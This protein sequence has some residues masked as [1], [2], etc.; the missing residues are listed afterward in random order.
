M[1][2]KVEL[3]K[4]FKVDPVLKSYF[5]AFVLML[6]AL[7]ILPWW[8]PLMTLTTWAEGGQGATLSTLVILVIFLVPAIVWTPL[9]HRSLVYGLTDDEVIW[10]RG[11]LF[12]KTSIVPYT[13]ITNVDIHQ[14]PLMRR[15]GIYGLNV[16]TAG[17]S[18][19]QAGR[20]EIS[21]IGVKDH[22]RLRNLIMENV[23]R[24]K[25]GTPHARPLGTEELMLEELKKIRGLLERM[26]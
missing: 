3:N 2:V 11:V 15:F 14:G 9:Y 18:V 4:E 1:G 17:Y 19:Q 23:R 26:D 8:L 20:S 25:R 5:L 22:D 16:Q 7:F 6:L 24:S 12:R 10:S 13:K 21:I